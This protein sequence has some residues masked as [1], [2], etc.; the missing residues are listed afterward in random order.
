MVISEYKGDFTRFCF[1]GQEGRSIC[2]GD[3]GSPI[4]HN[5]DGRQGLIDPNKLRMQKAPDRVLKLYSLQKLC[6]HH[7]FIQLLFIV[8]AQQQPQPQQQND[9]P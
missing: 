4:I 2:G 6:Y 1:G 7:H 9:Q 5:K 8:T 3:S